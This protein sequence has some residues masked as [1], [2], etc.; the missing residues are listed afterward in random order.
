VPV[1]TGRA[2]DGLL[3]V[4]A[5]ATR[6]DGHWLAEKKEMAPSGWAT[7]SGALRRRQRTRSTA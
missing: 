3:P 1:G 5:S 7:Q 4:A 6:A 2:G